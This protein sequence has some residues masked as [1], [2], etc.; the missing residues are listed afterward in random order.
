[1]S[2]ADQILAALLAGERITP[3]D[4]L[5]RFRCFRLAA[6]I[7]DLRKAG[8]DIKREDY[9]TESG[10]TVARYYMERPAYPV[11]ADGQLGMFAA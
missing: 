4:A 5:E 2:Q 3:L 1:M 9:E 7:N 8:Y 6:R 11:E 10:K